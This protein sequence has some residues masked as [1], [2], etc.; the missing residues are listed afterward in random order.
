[1][2]GLPLTEVN[3]NGAK[4]PKIGVILMESR[5]NRLGAT[6]DVR[7]RHR[8]KPVSPVLMILLEI[9]LVVSFPLWMPLVVSFFIIWAIRFVYNGRSAEAWRRKHAAM[10]GEQARERIHGPVEEAWGRCSDALKSQAMVGYSSGYGLD[11][12]YELMAG[13]ARRYPNEQVF[14]LRQ[15][16]TPTPCLQATRRCA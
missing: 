7:R 12:G 8:R 11:L 2:V 6:P 3:L 5:I 1:M 13:L 16:C 9:L 10:I 4:A 14:F 15:L